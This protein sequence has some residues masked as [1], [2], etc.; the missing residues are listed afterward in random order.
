MKKSMIIMMM[1]V[2]PV[3]IMNAQEPALSS[4]KNDAAAEKVAVGPKAS[5]EAQ[6][7]D[8]GEVTFRVSKDAEFKLTNTGNQPLLITSAKASCGCTNLRYSEEPI[9]PGKTAIMAVT[10]NGTGNGPFRKSITVQT[11]DS[12]TPTVLQITGTVIKTE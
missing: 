4:K 3:F 7:V 10:F 2:L 12:Q 6:I 9:L 5:W 8:L 1:M 11:N